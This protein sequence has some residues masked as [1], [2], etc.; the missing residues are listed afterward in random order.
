MFGKGFALAVGLE[1][2]NYG[3]ETAYGLVNS[4]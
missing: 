4:I 2:H 1:F 3:L